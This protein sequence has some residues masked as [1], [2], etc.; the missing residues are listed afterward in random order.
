MINEQYT[1]GVSSKEE[2]EV[3]KIA[4]AYADTYKFHI[5]NQE[6]DQSYI[7]GTAKLAKD[8]YPTVK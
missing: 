8:R 6:E 1:D 4:Q 5:T 7:E 3:S 2:E